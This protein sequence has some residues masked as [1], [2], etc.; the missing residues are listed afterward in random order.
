L[1]VSQSATKAE[2]K[3]RFYAL[4]KKYHPDTNRTL[5]E[6]EQATRKR[7]FQKIR[8][9]YEVLG[10]AAKRRDYDASL[11]GSMPEFDPYGPTR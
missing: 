9:A 4:S 3:R 5:S 1:G 2:I 10:N 8:D 11:G 7:Q 6:Q